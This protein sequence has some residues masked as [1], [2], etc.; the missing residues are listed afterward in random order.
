MK[1]AAFALVPGGI[2]VWLSFNGGGFFAGEPALAAALLCVLLVLR[3]T[4]FS[5]PG[6]GFGPLL[7]AAAVPLALLTAWTLASAGW[8]DAPARAVLE[9]DRVLLYLLALLLAGSFLRTSE[10][11]RWTVRGV[12]AGVV[13]VCGI[14]L[15]T[16][17]LPEV[18]PITQNIHPG[19]LSYPLTYWNAMGLLAG[20]GMVL[21]FALTSDERESKAGRVLAAA[22]LPVLGPALV[23]TSSRGALYS[24]AV[25]LGA[26]ALIARPRGF[27]AGFLASAPL[28]AFVM[29]QAHRSDWLFSDNPVQPSAVAEGQDLAVLIGVCVVAAAVLRFGLLALDGRATRFEV[30][31][32]MRRW[33]AIPALTV[34]VVAAAT[35]AITFNVGGEITDRYDEFSAEGSVASDSGGRLFSTNNNGRLRAWRVAVDAF[36]ENPLHGSGAGTFAL[37]WAK[38]RKEAFDQ[39]DAHSLYVEILGELGWV[40]LV[41]VLATLLAVLVGVGMRVREGERALYGGILAAGIAWAVSCGFDWH[42]ESAAVTLPFF[43]LGGAALASKRPLASA[44]GR[45]LRV[46]VGIALLALAITPARVAVSQARLDESISHFRAG[47]CSA[48]ID[49]ALGSTDAFGSRPQPFEVLAWCDARLGHHALAERMAQ[50]AI[51]R[52]PENWELHYT[53]ALVRGAGRKDPLPAARSALRLNPRGELTT[54]AVRRFRTRNPWL[55]E[56]RARSAR[57]PLR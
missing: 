52:D 12:A 23:L 2:V 10:Q 7:L 19:R 6:D 3:V 11:V 33:L 28:T 9:F 8:S 16:R 32:R 55:W 56:K 25:A 15:V 1:R 18:W 4:L 21:C 45:T 5:E 37:L 57:L 35:A 40:G 38:D 13:V 20:L 53:L 17:V 26:Y 41:L 31:P 44:P 29:L 24:T 22:A 48:A 42:W 36:E 34:A 50:A 30:S 49:S 54:E 46:V 14:G 47:D 51:K 27:P 43:A 39:Q